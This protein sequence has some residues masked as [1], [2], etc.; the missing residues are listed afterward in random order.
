M[1]IKLCLSICIKYIR[2]RF[3]Q[4]EIL[5]EASNKPT[6]ILG[7]SP[8]PSRYS[9]LAT[10][11]LSEHGHTVYPLGIRDGKI[12]DYDILRTKQ[13]GFQ[14]HTVTLYLGEKHQQEWEDYILSLN[15]KRIIFN[16]GAENHS[17]F[18][19]ASQKGIHCLEACTLVMLASNTF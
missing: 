10:L 9:Y 7:A 13:N 18:V 14:V 5:M 11:R 15:P 6:L 12:G 17:L 8:N 19:K 2:L 4:I 3:N 16:P 1:I